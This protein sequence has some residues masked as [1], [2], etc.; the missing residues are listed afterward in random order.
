MRARRVHAGL[1]AATC[2]RPAGGTRRGSHA[3]DADR[4]ARTGGQVRPRSREGCD[5]RLLTG[6]D[7]IRVGRRGADGGHHRHGDETGGGWCRAPREGAGDPARVRTDRDESAGIGEAALRSLQGDPAPP[8]GDGHL[9]KESEA[10][11]ASGIRRRLPDHPRGGRAAVF[12]GDI[13]RGLARGPDRDQYQPA[14]GA[15]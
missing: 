8:C 10:Q 2:E 14:R 1:W 7:A 5:A 3:A 13:S 12:P 15:E 4:R 11:A 6:G 9:Q